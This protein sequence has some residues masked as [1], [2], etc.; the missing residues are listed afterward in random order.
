M[1]ASGVMRGRHTAAP[2]NEDVVVLLMGMRFNH[3]W[4]VDKWWFV[5]AGMRRMLA[6]LRRGDYGLLASHSWFGRTTMTVQYWSSMQAPHSFA[7]AAGAPHRAAW[8]EYFRPI[9]RRPG[10]GRLPQGVSAAPVR[11]RGHLREH[12]VF[13]LAEVTEH[14]PVDAARDTEPARVRY[15]RAPGSGAGQAPAR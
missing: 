15:R 10:G 3:W 9:G 2:R 7:S 13:G 8:L 14:A 1:G 6:H 11:A 4:R 5:L 12:A